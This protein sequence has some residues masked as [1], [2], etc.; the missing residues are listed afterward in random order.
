MSEVLSSDFLERQFG[1]TEIEVMFHDETGLER[2]IA[3]KAVG[4]GRILEI[5]RVVFEPG[6]AEHFP[7]VF[8][9]MGD[10]ES[11]GKAFGLRGFRFTRNVKAAFT[12]DLPSVFSRWFGDVH[13]ATVIDLVASAGPNDTPVARIL[14]TYRPEVRWPYM[15]GDPTQE[16]SERLRLI[17]DFLADRAKAA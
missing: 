8:S 10:G 6:A 13:N 16:Q 17:S 2:I 9:A 3:T 7:E 1:P 15:Q 12:Y 5:S 14:E 4:D 11:M